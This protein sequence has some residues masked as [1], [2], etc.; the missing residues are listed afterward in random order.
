MFLIL[1]IKKLSIKIFYKLFNNKFKIKIIIENF[2]NVCMKN[3]I[4]I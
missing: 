3:L 2:Y 1:V 4:F